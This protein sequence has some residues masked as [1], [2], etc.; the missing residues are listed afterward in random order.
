VSSS[1]TPRPS[2]D[3]GF[4]TRWLNGNALYA[5][6][7]AL[8]VL[9]GGWWTVLIGTLVEDNL[10]L[11]LAQG[12]AT[13]E[14]LA[15]YEGKRR[16]LLGESLTMTAL[17]L[18]LVG[19]AVA[20]A[21]RERDQARR[22][23]DVLAA[24]THELKTP[25]AAVKALLESIRSGVLPPERLGPYVD[26]GLESTARLEHLVES[27]SAYQAAVVRGHATE[28]R[29]LREW[30][31]PV[32]EHRRATVTDEELR[33]ELGAAADAPVRAAADGFRVVLENLL[34]NA[35]KYGNGGPVQLTGRREGGCVVLEVSDAGMGFGPEDAAR[36]FEPYQR[37]AAAERRHG[38]GL[39]LYISRLRARARDGELAAH[40]AGRGQ[41][42][43]FALSLRAG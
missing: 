29:P 41:G 21:R 40:S 42:S 34:D 27:I 9:L 16:M 37:T 15:A 1:R 31:R 24:S 30:V 35:R 25:L 20:Q 43:T 18:A 8:L 36:I 4:L 12:G 32:L 3:R 7:F 17:L 33:V 39:G 23:E 11:R 14:V 5:V 10:E 28:S 13:A 22:L 38:T 26:R 2:S 6:V 19:G